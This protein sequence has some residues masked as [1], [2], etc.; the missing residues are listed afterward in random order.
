MKSTLLWIAAAAALA[1][2]QA[3]TS[4]D[5]SA[6][7]LTASSASAAGTRTKANA[8]GLTVRYNVPAGLRAGQKAVVQVVIS[9]ARASDASVQLA[10]DSAAL[11]VLTIDGVKPTGPVA[12]AP[13]AER[14]MDV[15]VSA[16]SDGIHYLN[17]ILTQ[18]GRRSA[19]AV[20][21]RVGTG[22]VSMKREGQLQTTP[23]GERIISLPAN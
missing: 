10:G 23:S 18:N 11:S 15:E 22:S 3:D 16:S 5:T 19:S 14:R 2:A 1:P 6:K 21:L 7:P 4:L 8:S 12:L 9:G 17:V 20:A 13:G